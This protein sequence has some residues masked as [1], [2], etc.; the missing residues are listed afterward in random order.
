M[1]NQ[2]NQNPNPDQRQAQP[3]RPDQGGRNP[4]Q[5]RPGPDKERIDKTRERDQ[6]RPQ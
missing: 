4:D 6:E 2:P 5:E 1:A 3:G